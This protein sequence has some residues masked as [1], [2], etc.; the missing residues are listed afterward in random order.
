MRPFGEASGSAQILPALEIYQHRNKPFAP[1]HGD[2]SEIRVKH[3]GRRIE[4]EHR[5]A[6]D[7]EVS[8]HERLILG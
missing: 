5:Q 8:F 1:T 6:S 3:R 2:T 4:E 7:A